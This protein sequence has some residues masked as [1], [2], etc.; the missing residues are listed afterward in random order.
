MN[1]A[2]LKDIAV[3]TQDNA[4]V[5]YERAIRDQVCQKCTA[6]ETAGDYCYEGFSRTC[7]LSVMAP[8]VLLVI[9]SLLSGRVTARG[10]GETPPRKSTGPL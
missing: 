7:P 4:L 1:L 3:A 10:G 5:A 9:E 2:P 8:N 6:T